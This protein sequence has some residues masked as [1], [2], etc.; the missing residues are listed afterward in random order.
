MKA[1]SLIKFFTS[2]ERQLFEQTVIKNHKRKSLK[3]L[4]KALKK[5][6]IPEKEKLFEQVF[7]QAYEEKKDTVLRN[8]LRLLSNAI[9]LFLVQQQQL[10]TINLQ[11]YATKFSLLQVYAE[12]QEWGYFE[13][14]WQKLYKTAVQEQQYQQQVELLQLWLEK[15]MLTGENDQAW[16]ESL[17]HQIHQAQIALEAQFQ[18]QFLRLQVKQG[19]VQRNRYALNPNYTPQLPTLPNSS[20]PLPNQ[21]ALDYLQLVAEGYLLHGSAKIKQ[22]EQALKHQPFLNQYQ[23]YQDLSLDSIAVQANIAIEYFLQKDYATAHANYWALLPQLE[24]LPAVKSIAILFNY[25]VN[26]ICLGK[27]EQAL[28]IYEKHQTAFAQNERFKYR[29]LYFKAWCHILLGDYEQGL[30]LVLQSQPQNRPH[31]D[32]IYGRMLLSILYSMLGELE[33]AERELYNIKQKHHYSALEEPFFVG[34][35]TLFHKLTSLQYLPA[36]KKRTQK[37][38]QLQKEM[39]DN[40]GAGDNTTNSTLMLRW[41]EQVMEG[42]LEK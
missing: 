27:Y 34:C 5:A 38:K 21:E 23:A 10:K 30:D 7:E 19:F 2:K 39:Q 16:F 42:I 28:E 22:L 41:F 25:L 32:G 26:L 6:S 1:K 4:Y 3:K 29:V 15:K 36:S 11:H 37:V 13:Q 40:Y 33:L 20:T 17:E 14:L 9:E 12:R 31:Q 8:E 35:A 24:A 18:E